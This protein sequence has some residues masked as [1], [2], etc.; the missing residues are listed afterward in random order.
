M[1]T[2]LYL[3]RSAQTEEPGN[4]NLSLKFSYLFF[5]TF[6]RCPLR[7]N[8][9]HQKV[10]ELCS[11]DQLGMGKSELDVELSLSISIS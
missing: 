2:S 4:G 7:K 6:L 5:A 1:V 3:M 11:E 8:I 10:S 9:F